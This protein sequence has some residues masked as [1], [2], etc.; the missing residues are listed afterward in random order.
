MEGGGSSRGFLSPEGS[1]T[2]RARTLKGPVAPPRRGVKSRGRGK[3][4]KRPPHATAPIAV[5]WGRRI[6]GPAGG[7]FVFVMAR[8]SSV[9]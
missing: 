9:R 5:T 3:D 2:S 4:L 1:R 8:P 7:L 6:G